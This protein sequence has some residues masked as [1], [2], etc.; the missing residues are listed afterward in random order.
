MGEFRLE[1]SLPQ[2][3]LSPKAVCK[4]GVVDL[5]AVIDPQSMASLGHSGRDSERQM[6]DEVDVIPA[7]R[8]WEE[9]PVNHNLVGDHCLWDEICH[10]ELRLELR[11]T[12]WWCS[13][14]SS[15]NS[16]TRC[17][18]DGCCASR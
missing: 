9:G 3:G 12:R 2:T 1:D 13:G 16:S 7:E 18:C 15:S 4:G 11:P 5:E 10:G 17:R 14:S 8:A 6:T